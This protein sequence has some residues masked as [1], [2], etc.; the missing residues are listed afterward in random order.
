MTNTTYITANPQFTSGTTSEQINWYDASIQ[1]YRE[2][3]YFDMGTPMTWYQDAQW[4]IIKNNRPH[5]GEAIIVEGDNKKDHEGIYVQT[6]GANG[7]FPSMR[8]VNGF[9]IQWTNNSTAGSAMFLR[10]IGIETCKA[11]GSYS[12]RWSTT[13]YAPPNDYATK[14]M[15]GTFS[16][17]DKQIFADDY[18]Y[19]LW[20]QISSATAGTGSR[21]TQV[22]LANFKLLYSAGTGTGSRWVI[23]K[24]RKKEV[25]FSESIQGK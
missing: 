22:T 8:H 7:L 21:V 12:H 6:A 17:A 23:G 2:S 10:K 4:P 24:E 20:F 11:D 19:R 9:R 16:N 15:T 25:A 14:T 1:N 13:N 18:F 5:L 3:A